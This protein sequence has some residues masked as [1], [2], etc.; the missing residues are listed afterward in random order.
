[1]KNFLYVIGR[2]LQN[3]FLFLKHNAKQVILF[4]LFSFIVFFCGNLYR[5]FNKIPNREL[6]FVLRE[7]G[8]IDTAF[9]KIDI[10][11]D[12][13]GHANDDE[14]K[15][16]QIEIWKKSSPDAEPLF[17]KK[18]RDR[19]FDLWDKGTYLVLSRL[20]NDSLKNIYS[21]ISLKV[22]CYSNVKDLKSS[23][24]SPCVNSDG[25]MSYLGLSALKRDGKRNYIGNVGYILFPNA[26]NGQG[27]FSFG[28]SVDNGL[29]KF[30]FPWDISQ[31]NFKFKFNSY[32]IECEKLKFEFYGPTEFSTMYPEP[33]KITASSI[34]FTDAEKMHI[35]M[36][37]GLCFHADFL[38][39]KNMLG[40]RNLLITSIM[41]IAIAFLCNIIW[42][43]IE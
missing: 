37:D 15:M 19:N 9:C 36:A 27:T 20:F 3:V 43:C 38:D 35:I 32:P 22:M 14:V 12:Y 33:D 29:Q 8:S 23:N 25:S 10:N 24:E 6:F 39:C 41:S 26:P 18:N 34:E 21:M 13:G 28:N 7:Y 40:V 16:T 1:M 4:A 42:K 17:P 31:M 11:M 30:W 5:I 2:Y